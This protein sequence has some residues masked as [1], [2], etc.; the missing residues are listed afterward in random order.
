MEDF[1][2]TDQYARLAFWT[3]ELNYCHIASGR[4]N[5]KVTRPAEVTSS[6]RHQLDDEA[7]GYL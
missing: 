2:P 5:P 4:A 6:A 1:K 7:F 3:S